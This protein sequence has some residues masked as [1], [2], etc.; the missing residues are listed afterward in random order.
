M[1]WAGAVGRQQ[2]QRPQ[3]H[4]ARFSQR[5][6]RP[7]SFARRIERLTVSHRSPDRFF[8]DRSEIAFDLRAMAARASVKSYYIMDGFG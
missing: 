1:S 7:V 5:A 8:E 4:P 6:P 3:D 2:Y